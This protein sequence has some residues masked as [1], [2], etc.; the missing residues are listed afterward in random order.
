MWPTNK[1]GKRGG[2]GGALSKRKRELKYNA[3][4]VVGRPELRSSDPN[5]WGHDVVHLCEDAPQMS[6]QPCPDFLSLQGEA[7]SF[8][9]VASSQSEHLV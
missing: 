2:G 5:S 4:E 9:K 7:R 1:S 8:L 6:Q 3:T